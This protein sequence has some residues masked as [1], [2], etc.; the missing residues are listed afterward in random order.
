MM[1]QRFCAWVMPLSKPLL[2]T[3]VSQTCLGCAI[4]TRRT[5]GFFARSLDYVVHH[6]AEGAGKKTDPEDD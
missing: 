4:V 3:T 1:K 6:I 2:G 5:L